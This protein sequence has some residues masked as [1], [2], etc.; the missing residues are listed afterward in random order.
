MNGNVWKYIATFLTSVLLTVIVGWFALI[1]D[2]SQLAP[3][4]EL[5]V[6]NLES[7]YQQVNTRLDQIRTAQEEMKR[8]QLLIL[9]RLGQ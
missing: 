4:V 2:T 8:T 9:Q 7:S 1:K 6:S 5:R 3:V